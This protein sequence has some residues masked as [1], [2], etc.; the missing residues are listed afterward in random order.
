[1]PAPIRQQAIASRRLP[2]EFQAIEMAIFRPLT[3]RYLEAAMHKSRVAKLAKK[4]FNNC[5]SHDLSIG[6][7]HPLKIQIA[8][9]A[10]ECLPLK[11]ECV[12]SG[13]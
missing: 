10:G 4:I 9:D 2:D 1:L 3:V 11:F 8:F 12:G 7:H 6:I 13:R 5:G